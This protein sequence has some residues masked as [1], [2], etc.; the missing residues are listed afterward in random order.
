[1]VNTFKQHL[2]SASPEASILQSCFFEYSQLR[3][4]RTLSAHLLLYRDRPPP[5]HVVLDLLH[6]PGVIICPDPSLD[7]RGSSSLR[8]NASLLSGKGR[9]RVDLGVA[10]HKKKI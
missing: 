5:G 2:L 10:A 4:L 7:Y 3:R 6:S 9:G 8:G 1:M